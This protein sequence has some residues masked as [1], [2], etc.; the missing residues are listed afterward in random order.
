MMLDTLDY[1]VSDVWRDMRHSSDE[2]LHVLKPY[3]VNLEPNAAS[4][5]DLKGNRVKM[6]TRRGVYVIYIGNTPHY[7]GI[8]DN[9]YGLRSRFQQRLR[10]FRE[11]G[12]TDVQFKT[13][14]NNRK[15]VWAAVSVR[16]GNNDGVTRGDNGFRDPAGK[17]LN[18]ITGVLKVLEQHLIKKL[19]TK[20]KGNIQSE[21]VK[22]LGG[23]I[24]L[25]W[26]TRT[27]G[28]KGSR[29]SIPVEFRNVLSGTI[30][31][32]ITW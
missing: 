11:L 16:T 23:T 7:V 31:T 9:K 22:F 18:K 14:F 13:L 1:M 5:T 17:S 27:R 4:L 25:P 6:P 20:R 2:E 26:I 29:V 21:N 12:V 8:A 19:D 3:S 28:T 15:V 10:V 32:N 30:N 24:D